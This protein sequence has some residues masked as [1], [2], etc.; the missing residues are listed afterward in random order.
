MSVCIFMLRCHS[1]RGTLIPRKC[2]TSI[3]Y[4]IV[5]VSM[6][7]A[8]EIGST[9][10]LNATLRFL[11]ISASSSVA[12]PTTEKMK[13]VRFMELPLYWAAL[14]QSDLAAY[15]SYRCTMLGFM[16]CSPRK[17]AQLWLQPPA[18]HFHGPR[19]PKRITA[20]VYAGVCRTGMRTALPF[21]H[22]RPV[23]TFGRIGHVC[24]ND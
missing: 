10:R 5:A 21:D 3:S 13:M 20:V 24:L 15:A 14:Q 7:T 6:H 16:L 8:I 2:S 9:M 18:V 19:S 4:N 12:L 1:A 23:A 22:R 17:S 11:T